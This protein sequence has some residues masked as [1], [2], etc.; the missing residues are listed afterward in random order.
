MKNQ[1]S[2]GRTLMQ[3][4]GKHEPEWRAINDE[5]MGG[6]ST[7]GP[8]LRDG[9]LHFLGTLSLENNGG[10]SSVRAK[11][12]T[13][14]L[15]D[16][17]ALAIRVKGD[18]RTYQIRLYTDARHQGSRIAYAASFSTKPDEWMETEIPFK[19]LRPVFRGRKLD[20]PPID[21]TSIEEVGFLI[22]DRRE[23]DFT[24]I[25]DWIKAI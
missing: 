15:S 23:G 3:F 9:K 6:R 13:Y 4:S 25:V 17:K 1:Y 19:A 10:F 14:D 2:D 11:G 7:G 22:A 21:L 24:L 18:G 20:G 5:V 12:K 8:E 16:A